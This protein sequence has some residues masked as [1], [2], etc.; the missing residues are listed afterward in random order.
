MKRKEFSSAAYLLENARIVDFKNANVESCALLIEAGMIRKKFTGSGSRPKAIRKLNLHGK[1][2]IPGFIDGHTHLIPEGIKMQQLDLSRC[3]SLEDCLKKIRADLKK[4]D[5][6]FASNWD[7]ASW[8]ASDSKGLNRHTLD[9]LSRKKPIIMR[10]ICG[11]Y[12]VVNTA[13]LRHIPEN[14]R[15]V[16]RGSGILYE[17]AA[18]NLNDFFPPTD[19][20]LEEAVS[21]AANKAL[22]LGITSVHEIS[23]PR[24]FRVLQKKRKEL[25]IRYAI[26][27]TERYHEHVLETGLRTGYG[28]DWLRFEGTKVF[29]DGS[30]GARTAALTR[31][32]EGT[33]RRGNIL[34]STSRLKWFVDT[35]ESSGI[36]LML[37]SIGD[38]TTKIALRI[39]KERVAQGNPLRH[40]IEHLEML[41]DESVAEMGR[42][43]IIAS[44]QPNFVRRW[45]N[46]GGM[47]EKVLGARYIGMNRFRSLLLRRVRLLFGS[48]CMP[49]GPLY[50]L[51]GAISH[52][53][54]KER[55]SIAQ[56]LT[57]YTESGAFAT[58]EERK[59]GKLEQGYLADLVVLNGNPLERE[60]LAALA[61][62][63]VIVGGEIVY[64]TNP[65]T[66]GRR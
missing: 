17:D 36:Q 6:V 30:I 29:V 26:Y 28:D 34:V 33:H 7:E 21:L 65:Q 52:P 62:Q 12:A 60:N 51:Q 53:S 66:W 38:R 18:L 4:Q 25:K 42:M 2:V 43:K 15:I 45:Q 49:L 54:E 47:Y 11:H 41:S 27:L 44:M 13:A 37:H 40:R 20:M 3:R 35:A 31:P 23:K 55:L 9:R 61:I 10:R 63:M 1:Y 32:Y 48:D 5:I 57:T 8:R 14:R 56:S 50:G 22:R 58:F 16:D 59:K 64:G 24:Y 39:L 46:P 19:E